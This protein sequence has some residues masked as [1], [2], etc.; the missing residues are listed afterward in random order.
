MSNIPLSSFGKS[1]D[2]PAPAAAPAPAPAPA[3]TVT[4]VPGVDP[5]HKLPSFLLNDQPAPSVASTPVT[6]PALPEKLSIRFRHQDLELPISEVQRLAQ[7]GMSAQKID[8]RKRELDELARANQ[9]KIQVADLL[10]SLAQV[11]PARYR[12]VQAILSGRSPVPDDGLG[13]N[14]DDGLTP[15]AG[16]GSMTPELEMRLARLE[17]TQTAALASLQQRDAQARLQGALSKHEILRTS[18]EAEELARLQIDAMMRSGEVEDY[19][20]AALIAADRQRKLIQNHMDGERRK[21][22]EARTVTPPR[23]QQASTALPRIDPSQV[24]YR[25]TR[26]GQSRG[27]LRELLSK[28]RAATNPNE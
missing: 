19:D 22:E 13:G 8:E 24:S 15:Q 21:R 3:P 17:Q 1:A 23:S 9:E 25:G 16:G 11:D 18:P 10:G 4:D 6:A 14:V 12:Q 20:T 2:A 27:A 7:I 5:R 26:N 28:I